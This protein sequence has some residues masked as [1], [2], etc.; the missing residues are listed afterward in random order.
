MYRDEGQQMSDAPIT[1][2]GAL[3]VALAAVSALSGIAYRSV[4]S[5]IEAAEKRNEQENQQL[6][7]AVEKQREDIKELLKVVVTKDDLRRSEDRIVQAV[8]PGG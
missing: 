3:G 1:A 6:W 7:G 5:R 4:V 2:S 8:R